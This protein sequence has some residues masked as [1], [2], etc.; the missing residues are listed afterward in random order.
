MAL[1]NQGAAE[2]ISTNRIKKN[3]LHGKQSG[4]DPA[5]YIYMYY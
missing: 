2:F 4:S 1:H 3:L 5:A